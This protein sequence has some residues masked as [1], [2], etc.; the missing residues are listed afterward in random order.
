MH[1]DQT[2]AQLYVGESCISWTNNPKTCTKPSN[3][4]WI[5]IG[6]HKKKSPKINCLNK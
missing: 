3:L 1:P 4:K 2:I 5:H 6:N